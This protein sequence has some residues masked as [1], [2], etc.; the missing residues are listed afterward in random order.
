M[1][2][3]IVVVIECNKRP[4]HFRIFVDTYQVITAFPHVAFKRR[5]PAVVA[6]LA[7]LT[8][9]IGYEQLSAWFQPTLQR[10]NNNKSEEHN[11]AGNMFAINIFSGER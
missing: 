1:Q 10:N 11:N 7:L 6:A 5:R 8:T 9:V 4:T 3:V 2:F